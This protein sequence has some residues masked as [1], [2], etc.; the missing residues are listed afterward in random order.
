MKFFNN[1]HACLTDEKLPIYLDA[2]S[3]FPLQ[4]LDSIFKKKGTSFAVKYGQTIVELSKNP[5]ELIGFAEQESLL[6]LDQHTHHAYR[7]LMEYFVSRK[8]LVILS[9]I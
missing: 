7:L 2:I 3:N 4:V 1:A 6:P 9:S 5:F 8:S